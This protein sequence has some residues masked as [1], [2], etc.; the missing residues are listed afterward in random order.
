MER[1]MSDGLSGTAA[2]SFTSRPILP[3]FTR[4]RNHRW[5]SLAGVHRVRIASVVCSAA[6]T[7]DIMNEDS[8]R[9]F[10]SRL[11]AGAGAVVALGPL[12]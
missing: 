1:H 6:G 8:R 3:L 9:A 5:A 11:L 4:Y 2:A 7:G 12:A 10:L